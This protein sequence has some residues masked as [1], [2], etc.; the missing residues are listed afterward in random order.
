MDLALNNLQ[1]LI[2]RKTQTTNQHLMI[3]ISST[4][5]YKGHLKNTVNFASRV[6]NRKYYLQLQLFCNII[7]SD[8]SLHIS[9]HSQH[10]FLY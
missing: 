6:G 8:G 2:C 5:I 3:Y 10:D 4:I 9:E 1:R 7:E